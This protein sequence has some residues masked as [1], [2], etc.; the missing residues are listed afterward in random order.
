LLLTL[1]QADWQIRILY[2]FFI[3]LSNSRLASEMT[4][5]LF[6][7]MVNPLLTEMLRSTLEDVESSTASPQDGR[8]L[9]ELKHSIVRSVAELAVK[10]DEEPLVASREVASTSQLPDEEK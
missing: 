7:D 4:L 2:G 1:L 3:Q 9:S 6:L 10:R 8:A 5:G